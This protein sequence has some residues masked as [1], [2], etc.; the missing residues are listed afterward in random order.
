MIYYNFRLTFVPCYRWISVA[1]A[2]AAE[3]TKLRRSTGQTGGG[4][5][6][7]TDTVPLHRRSPLEAGSVISVFENTYFSFFSDL[8]KHDFLRFL[9]WH[10]KKSQKVISKSLVLNTSPRSDHFAQ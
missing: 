3:K 6:G 4:A 8:K 2:R 1:R 7:L 5:D 10:I 9:K